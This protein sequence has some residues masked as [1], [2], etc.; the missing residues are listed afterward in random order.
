VLSSVDYALWFGSA[1][2]QAGAVVCAIRARSL[3]RFFPLNLY[4]A[5]AF[6]LTL[7]RYF[8]FWSYGILSPQYIYFY[9]Y[10]DALLTV[11]LFFALIGLYSQVLSELRASHY[12]RIS[13]ILL[14]GLTA[15]FS[16]SIAAG[17]KDRL[18]TKFVVELGQNMNFVGVVLTYLLWGLVMKLRETRTQ[19]IQLILALGV[20]FSA[21]AANYALRNLYPSL[22]MVWQY[23]PPLMALWLPLAWAYTFLKT[24][25]DAR[26]TPAHVAAPNR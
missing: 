8:V 25:D 1:I 10:S 26:L 22:S 16:Y 19:L 14:L 15:L 3:F 5:V 18:I 23:V 2:L 9:Y 13:A 7:L 6:L 17:S 4:M 21:F 24:P 12:V 11:F 20:Y